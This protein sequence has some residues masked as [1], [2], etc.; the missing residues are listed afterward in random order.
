[1]KKIDGLVACICEGITEEIIIKLLLENNLLIFDR[2]L[3]DEIIR[4]R[5]AEAFEKKYLRKGFVEKLTIIRV[6]D[7]RREKFELSDLYAEKVKVINIITAPEIEMLIIH[8]ENKYNNYCK[9]KM[10][11]SEYCK[12]ILKYK[13][14]KEREFIEKYFEDYEKLTRAIKKH[15]RD[16][17][18]G[19]NEL[20]LA[21]LLK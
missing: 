21:D 7:S 6:L 18:R 16:S 19:R 15:K 12:T 8:S 2:L 4:T 17:K 11:P 1:M 13:N 5:S 3:D 20:C 9:S 10:K 14:V